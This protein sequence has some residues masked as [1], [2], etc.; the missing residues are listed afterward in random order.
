MYFNSMFNLE[1]WDDKCKYA[2]FDDFEDWSKWYAYKQ[3]LGAQHEFTV[4]DKYRRKRQ[5]KWGRPCIVLSNE[6]PPFRDMNWIKG[7]CFIKEINIC[8]F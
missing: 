3:F 4:T 6:V 8:L 2:V 7:N 1:L 5:V